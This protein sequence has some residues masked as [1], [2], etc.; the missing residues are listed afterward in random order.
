MDGDRAGPE[1]RSSRP[2]GQGESPSQEAGQPGV[3]VRPAD[4]VYHDH[5]VQS[6]ERGGHRGS[7]RPGGLRS[8]RGACHRHRHT[9]TSRDLEREEQRIRG[10]APRSHHSLARECEGGP[11]D[12]PS[13]EPLRGRVRHERISA[14]CDGHR[15]VRVL[16]MDGVDPSVRGVAEHVPRQKYGRGHGDHE[17][18]RRS[19]QHRG[20]PDPV[21]PRLKQEED[22][23]AYRRHDDRERQR[24]EAWPVHRGQPDRAGG[25]K[26]PGG[27]A[28]AGR[29]PSGERRVRD[30]GDQRHDEIRR[31]QHRDAPPGPG[32]G[33][34]RIRG[35]TRPGGVHAVP[36]VAKRHSAGPAVHTL[37]PSWRTP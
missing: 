6:D 22:E 11:I 21:R 20:Q 18:Q 23:R 27:W 12:R 34:N 19:R 36:T 31:H 1:C 24:D 2:D 14:E 30:R 3:H 29:Q 8:Q 4:G 13:M 15:D 7:L 9:E 25:V 33:S 10:M 16:M 17:G 5:R 35:R 37:R 28:G 26:G 32:G